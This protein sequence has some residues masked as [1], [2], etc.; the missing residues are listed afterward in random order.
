M[1]DQSDEMKAYILVVAFLLAIVVVNLAGFVNAHQ[2]AANGRTGMQ[3]LQDCQAEKTIIDY[4]FG[5]YDGAF[6]SGPC[7]GYL[8]AFG[9]GL[10]N[11]LFC[12][13]NDSSVGQMALV[14]LSWAD[15][16]PEKL[17]EGA[18]ACASAALKEAFPCMA[19]Q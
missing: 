1:R 17:H 12:L 14:Y 5:D 4:H 18:A 6:T 16:H 15:R 7:L 3:L 8:R 9:H 19:K 2:A 11:K 10:E 13:P